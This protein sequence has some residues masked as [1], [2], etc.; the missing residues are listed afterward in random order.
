M[1][2]HSPVDI[3]ASSNVLK[4]MDWDG[5]GC[6]LNEDDIIHHMAM[7]GITQLVDNYEVPEQRN[8][9]PGISSDH[10]V[11]DWFHVG[12]HYVY[13]WLAKCLPPEDTEN[14]GPVPN[15]PSIPQP[16]LIDKHVDMGSR[17]AGNIPTDESINALDG[18]V[19]NLTS[20]MDG[21][22]GNSIIPEHISPTN[23]NPIDLSN[24]NTAVPD[25]EMPTST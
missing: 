25:K 20:D 24:M 11:F 15:S 12:E 3:A 8:D 7:N 9:R 17:M 14:V 21:S 2:P 5:P 13:E 19:V 23:G 16:V 22:L 10:T 1:Y 4:H 6:D 18:T